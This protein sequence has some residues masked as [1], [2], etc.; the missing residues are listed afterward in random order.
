M[1]DSEGLSS[2]DLSRLY[3]GL[4]RSGNSAELMTFVDA[5]SQYSQELNDPSRVRAGSPLWQDPAALMRNWGDLKGMSKAYSALSNTQ[6]AGLFVRM[7]TGLADGLGYVAG[8][9][10]GILDIVLGART[11]NPL[12]STAG[13]LNL[14]SGLTGMYAT[15]VTWRAATSA[16]AMVSAASAAWVA[17]GALAVLASVIS[18]FALLF[19]NRTEPWEE[20]I[21]NRIVS[22]ESSILKN[23]AHAYIW[24]VYSAWRAGAGA[25]GLVG[26]IPRG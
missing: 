7:G 20:D 25:N 17:A 6:L 3:D 10:T 16:L 18:V 15:Y 2:R 8:A 22:V 11:H 14:A 26:D 12:T 19:T 21:Y 4:L 1:E 5:Q 24:N 9:V 13:V 23:G